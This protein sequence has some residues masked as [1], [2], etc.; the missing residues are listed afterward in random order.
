MILFRFCSC[1]CCSSMGDLYNFRLCFELQNITPGQNKLFRQC[2]LTTLP[3]A[4]DRD[5]MRP[6]CSWLFL[7]FQLR[8]LYNS[9]TDPL[10]N[11]N[12]CQLYAVSF[13]NIY[14]CSMFVELCVT[15]IYQCVYGNFIPTM[16]R[17]VYL[18]KPPYGIICLLVRITN[19]WYVRNNFI[20]Y[21]LKKTKL[22]SFNTS[23][24]TFFL[25]VSNL[26]P[27]GSRE[28]QLP[29]SPRKL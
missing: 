20:S 23:T 2:C 8:R 1:L 27:R 4:F 5:A 6:K 11:A 29:P 21:V 7:L 16:L 12:G 18:A 17:I 9:Y 13:L 14:S 15:V 3:Q 28:A 25:N 10:K 19:Q 22:F 24:V 26:L